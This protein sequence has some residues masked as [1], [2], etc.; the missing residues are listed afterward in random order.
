M[1][2]YR[3]VE[4]DTPALRRLPFERM[5]AEGLTRAVIWNRADPCLLDWL[6]CVNPNHA[7]CWLAFDPDKN[8]AGLWMPGI[9]QALGSSA[10]APVVYEAE[11][12]PRE[13]EQEAE[14]VLRQ[15]DAN[16]GQA[17]EALRAQAEQNGQAAVEAVLR[18]LA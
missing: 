3:F 5:E 17:I 11:A 2:T 9:W 8:L 12:A 7:F 18:R 16:A 10:P 1:V 4:A 6:E 14:A 15:A 13:A